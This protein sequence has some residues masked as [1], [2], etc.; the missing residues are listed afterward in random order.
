MVSKN[1]RVQRLVCFIVVC[2]SLTLNC[3]DA[4]MSK[5]A[6]PGDD[7]VPCFTLN[8]E[9][10]SYCPPG[11]FCVDSLPSSGFYLPG[12]TAAQM[13]QSIVSAPGCCPN[14]DDVPCYSPVSS[15]FVPACCPNATVCCFNT[16]VSDYPFVGCAQDIQQCCGQS[17]CPPGYSCCRMTDRSYCCPGLDSCSTLWNDTIVTEGSTVSGASITF[18]P[19]PFIANT[20]AIDVN[21]KHSYS[22]CEE[23][24]NGTE[25]VP[26]DPNVAFPCG[27]SS[28][29][30]LV[31]TVSG[32]PDVCVDNVGNPLDA[33]NT[34]IIESDGAFCC[35]NNTDACVR[36]L[37]S[38]SGPGVFGCANT[39][40]GESCC[41]TQ[42]CPVDS[43]CCKVPSPPTW[44]TSLELQYL[45][46]NVSEYLFLGHR[47]C[48]VGT[49]CCAILLPSPTGDT[50]GTEVF[51]Y[52]G[53][54]SNCT[55][56][57]TMSE[58]LQPMP[59]LGLFFP[60]YIEDVG[61]MDDAQKVSFAS[62]LTPIPNTCDCIIAIQEDEKPGRD[63][64]QLE[65]NV[66]AGSCKGP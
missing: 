40:A 46:G 38:D 23:V 58:V 37:N 10:K 56:L 55:S 41:S 1:F 14:E 11:M 8:G 19:N 35:P 43:R 15:A 64:M 13:E 27:N 48:P 17:I 59:S 29:Y 61:W 26:W 39:T 32:V 54:N 66:K 18:T 49:F 24:I 20:R 3:A 60:D 28:S 45:T 65:L 2:A 5:Y 9:Q 57:A 30:C 53:R 62:Q 7:Y 44:V 6:V 12:T 50:G 51:T 21:A 25:R 33:S 34:T 52:C 63:Q 36:T 22:P 42:I 47:C 4:Q 16:Q 31:D